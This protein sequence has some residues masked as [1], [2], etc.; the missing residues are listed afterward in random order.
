MELRREGVLGIALTSRLDQ[1]R[2]VAESIYEPLS[3]IFKVLEPELVDR[4]TLWDVDH[5][6]GHWADG[7]DYF[8]KKYM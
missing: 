8:L 6:Y 5:I 4:N 1:G 7:R 2:L 3:Q